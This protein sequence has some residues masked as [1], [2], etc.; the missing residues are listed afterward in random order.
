MIHFHPH[1]LHRL[2]GDAKSIDPAL[3]VDPELAAISRKKVKTDDDKALLAPL[4]DHTLSAGAKTYLKEYASEF[5]F[6]YHKVVETRVLDKGIQCEQAVI[7]LYNAV[8]FTRHVK[9]SER[10]VDDYLTGEPD[11]IVPGKRTIDTKTCWDVSTFPILSEDCHDI[12]YE[13]Q[14][15]GYMRLADVPE[16][17]VAFGLVDTPEELIPKW[18]QEEL[19]RVGHHAPH[20]RI[21]TIT[22]KRDMVL[23]KLIETKCK[24][25]RAYLERIIAQFSIEHG[26]HPVT[27]AI[28]APGRG[29]RLAKPEGVAP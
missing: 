6:S 29:S 22:Y 21:T 1:S 23:E 9:N 8:H 12:A 7:D 4:W 19:H 25:G 2:M 28:T 5:L 26:I 20:M 14:G 15:R 24:A 3:L 10:L 11:I 18:E 27:V 17:Q 16:H 13:W